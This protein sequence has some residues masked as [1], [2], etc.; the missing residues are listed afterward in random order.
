M[1]IPQFGSV[2]GIEYLDDT[3]L[4]GMW[5]DVIKALTAIGYV[6][7]TLFLAHL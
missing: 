2:E 5:D 3:H 7:G 1:K 6:S 4:F